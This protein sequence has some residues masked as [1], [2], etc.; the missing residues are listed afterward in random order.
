MDR[1]R[2]MNMVIT[3][4]CEIRFRNVY[5]YIQFYVLVFFVLNCLSS[6]KLCFGNFWNVYLQCVTNSIIHCWYAYVFTLFN[7]LTYLYCFLYYTFLK[8]VSFYPICA[9]TVVSQFWFVREVDLLNRFQIVILN[10]ADFPHLRDTKLNV[11]I[12]RLV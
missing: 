9:M 2:G 7:D 8:F 5:F 4:K 6:N 1:R 11:G 3:L 12:Y 10:Y